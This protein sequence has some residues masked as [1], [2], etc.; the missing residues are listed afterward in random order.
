MSQDGLSAFREIREWLIRGTTNEPF[1][2]NVLVELCQRLSQA[3][4][5]IARGN[6]IV[7]TNHPQW[8]GARMLW[9]PGMERAE[10]MRLDYEGLNRQEFLQSPVRDILDGS[11][12]IRGQLESTNR[13]EDR[14]PLL[15]E[16][17]DAGMTDYAAWPLL[18]TRGQRH[19]VSFATDKQGG[20]SPDEVAG[21]EDI[22]SAF[23]LVAEIR[24][25]NR[26]AR[27]FLET[28]VGPHAS[29]QILAGATRRGSGVTLS[30]VIVV[31]DLRGFTAISEHW[32][33]DNVIAM[34]NDY[35]DAISDPV[36][37]NGGEILKF[38]GDG[39]LAIFP[40][41]SPQAHHRALRAV[42]AARSNMASLNLDRGSRGLEPLGYG[43]GVHV[44]DVMYGNIGSRSR[45][46]FTVIGPAVNVAS[47]L[48]ALT[49]RVG[50]GIL[51]SGDFVSEA[52]DQARFDALGALSLPGVDQ[53][54]EV[55]ALI[56]P[57]SP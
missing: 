12:H 5:A 47:R 53:P 27:T 41:E 18:F 40:L 14:Y 32:P 38:M 50:R 11:A 3:G 30:A 34:L 37:E 4:L 36:T 33:R 48:E 20:F 57:E 23:S 54:L 51:L 46:D 7:R 8:L 26:L 6:L 22:V 25:R 16:L 10:L 15:T 19:V 49:K 55:Y 31:Y 42:V 13:A 17:R 44:G 39:L 52:S 56:D 28:Y 35:F 2:D 1:I 21:L 29:E 45:L 9:R 24:L 43:V